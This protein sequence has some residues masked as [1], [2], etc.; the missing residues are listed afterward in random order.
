MSSHLPPTGAGTCRRVGTH[1]AV[2]PPG[3]WPC[4]LRRQP[5]LRGRPSVCGP[6]PCR[7][8][9]TPR[10]GHRPSWNTPPSAL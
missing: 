10:T 9:H 6:R 8:H 3:P 1:C 7:G 2:P 5:C 4:R